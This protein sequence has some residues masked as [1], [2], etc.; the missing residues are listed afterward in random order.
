M[1]SWVL[2]VTIV[3]RELKVN[4]CIRRWLMNGPLNQ[5]QKRVVQFAA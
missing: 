3:A 5:G 1:G 2:A 4:S